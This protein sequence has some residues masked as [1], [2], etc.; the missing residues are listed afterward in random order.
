MLGTS[1]HVQGMVNVYKAQ[2]AV[3]FKGASVTRDGPDMTARSL[4]ALY[5]TERHAMAKSCVMLGDVYA[6]NLSLVLTAHGDTAQDPHP[7]FRPLCIVLSI[8]STTTM[9]AMPGPN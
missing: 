5:S 6:C 4:A 8:T 3:C 7:S 2:R 1:L 9:S